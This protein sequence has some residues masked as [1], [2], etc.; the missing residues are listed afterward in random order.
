LFSIR[1]PRVILGGL[2]GMTLAVAG[3]VFRAL[4]R[5]PLAD[6]YLI[7]VSSGAAFG[8]TCAIYFIWQF[9]WGGFNAL[10]LSAFIGALAAMAAIYGLSR[11]GNRKIISVYKESITVFPRPDETSRPAVLPVREYDT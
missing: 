5:N 7:G 8:A 3:G 1:L 6:P 11:V 4:F 2:V 10:S 9:S